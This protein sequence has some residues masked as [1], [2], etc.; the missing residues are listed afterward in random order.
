M[1]KSREL[2]AVEE[3]I[4][5]WKPTVTRKLYNLGAMRYG[6]INLYFRNTIL[7]TGWA[8]KFDGF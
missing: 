6:N 7:C 5:I 8:I 3:T 1:H 4:N 2:L